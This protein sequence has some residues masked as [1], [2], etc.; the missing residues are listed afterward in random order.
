MN[1]VIITFV[2]LPNCH[3]ISQVAAYDHITA[4]KHALAQPVCDYHSS[5]T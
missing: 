1:N 5:T 3:D 2:P 4:K